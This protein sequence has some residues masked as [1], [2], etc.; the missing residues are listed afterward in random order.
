MR[1]LLKSIS[2]LALL[3]FFTTNVNAEE[4]WLFIA[5]PAKPKA[6][7]SCQ[8]DLKTGAFGELQ[9]AADD[10]ASGF[11]ALHPTKPIL[12]AAASDSDS[13]PNGIVIAYK[14]DAAT[15]KLK[16]INQAPTNDQGTTHI[17]IDAGGKFALICH[18]GGKGTSAIPLNDDGSLQQKVA[19]IEHKGSSV[20]ERRQTRPHPHGVAIHKDGKFVCVAD[21]GNDHVEV[22]GI[23]DSGNLSE[24][25]FWKSAPGAGPRH[26]SF[27]PNHKWLYCINE[28]D[29]TLAVLE[30]D[31]Q[32]GSLK[33]KQTLSTLPDDFEGTNSTAE[34][35]VH[36]TG[37]F[38][39]GSNRGHNSTAVFAIDQTNGTLK[40]VEREPT[41]G[42][43]PRHVGLDPTGHVYIAAN[44]KEN[45][46]VSF[47][48]DQKT[49]ALTPTGHQLE[50]ARPMC[51]VFVK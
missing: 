47:H 18:Y 42:D 25:S 49:G 32:N 3:S 46:L 51:V 44:M 40:F 15:G 4:Q 33:E 17:E 23:S 45:N 26:V 10:V 20:N 13:T 34:V 14:I 7:Y 48:I 38:L 2:F 22:F 27:H 16:K 29:S 12:Y 6:I 36:P 31:A 39:Y 28:L 9:T 5:S 1:S 30:F 43:H 35:V 41:Q 21:L 50:V 19:T 8:L 11:L 37:K 24:S